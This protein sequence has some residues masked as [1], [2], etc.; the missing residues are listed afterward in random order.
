MLGIYTASY[1][2]GMILTGAV[3]GGG[4]PLII[5]IVK[6]RPGIGVGALICCG[7]VSPIHPAA[8]LFVGL[9]FLVATIVI[10]KR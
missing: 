8:S 3:I 7:V 5:S 1:Y 9:V 2:F 10:K 4:I 6:K